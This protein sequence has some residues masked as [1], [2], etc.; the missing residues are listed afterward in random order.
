MFSWKEYTLPSVLWVT[1]FTILAG[2]LVTVPGPV[3]M[4]DALSS[5]PF[6]W[7]LLQPMRSLAHMYRSAPEWVLKG[8]SLHPSTHPSLK[9]NVSLHFCQLLSHYSFRIA[10]LLFYPVG[11]LRLSTMPMD[12]FCVFVF[13]PLSDLL[14]VD[15][16]T[17]PSVQSS[18]GLPPLPQFIFDNC[19]VFL[20][21]GFLFDDTYLFDFLFC[22][23][24]PMV[25]YCFLIRFVPSFISLSNFNRLIW[26]SSSD[27][28]IRLILSRV[29]SHC[30]YCYLS[31]FFS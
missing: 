31:S 4:P 21:P 24:H 12:C 25:S 7:F 20:Y 23:S 6:R 14:W 18:W 26:K 29:N 11:G 2:G 22:F 8:S 13:M 9:T 5:A 28:C 3:W 16:S 1:R 17:R 19:F 15:S 30:H 27:C 10:S